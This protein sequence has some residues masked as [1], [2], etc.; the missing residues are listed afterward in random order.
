[1]SVNGGNI[2]EQHIDAPD[3]FQFWDQACVTWM[4]DHTIRCCDQEAAA[5]LALPGVHLLIIVQGRGVPRPITAGY[6][7]ITTAF[8]TAFRNIANGADVQTELDNAVDAIDAD[9]EA[10]DFY[11]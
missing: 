10:N 3:V 11:K 8:S 9:L 5:I 6:P 1:M 7:T 2:E 4:P